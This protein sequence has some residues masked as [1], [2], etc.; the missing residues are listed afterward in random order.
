MNH[1]LHKLASKRNH[2]LISLTL[3]DYQNFEPIYC[4]FF[5]QFDLYDKIFNYNSHFAWI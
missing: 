5:Y 2:Q 3:K 4:R 1:Q